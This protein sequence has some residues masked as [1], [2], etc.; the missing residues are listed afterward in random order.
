MKDV[1]FYFLFLLTG[2]A[3]FGQVTLTGK[4]ENLKGEA[5]ENINVLIY[6]SHSEMLVAFGVTDSK[7]E[8]QVNMNIK[9]DSINVQTSSIHYEKQRIRIGNHA[10]N[11][12][13][14]LAPDV[15]QLEAFTVRAAAIDRRGDTLSFMVSSFAL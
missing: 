6:P 8:F 11:L 2:P 12:S 10:Q 15:K 3:L 9:A 13:F 14:K 4:V 5:L 1:C 7:G